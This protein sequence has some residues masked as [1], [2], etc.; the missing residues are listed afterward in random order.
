M[1]R[2][3]A[4]TGSGSW[5]Q[6]GGGRRWKSNI[7]QYHMFRILFVWV[8]QLGIN[9]AHQFHSVP[10][11]SIRGSAEDLQLT[12]PWWAFLHQPPPPQAFTRLQALPSVHTPSFTS[13][14]SPFQSES[15]PLVPPP[16][17]WLHSPALSPS[18]PVGNKISAIHTET[19]RTI[20]DVMRGDRRGGAARAPGERPRLYAGLRSR[21]LWPSTASTREPWWAR[22]GVLHHSDN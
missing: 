10:F 17:P 19:R 2:I 20:P 3:R 15:F 18:I 1:S 8:S 5:T 9:E 13:S 16:A 4:E 12:Q 14:P 6:V 7:R 22:R 11:R 21:R